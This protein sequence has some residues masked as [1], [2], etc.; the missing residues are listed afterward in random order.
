MK[1]QP[2]SHEQCREVFSE[3]ILRCQNLL[4]LHC[5]MNT[6]EIHATN[7]VIT[8]SESQ[9]RLMAAL[10]KNINCK[11][12]LINIVWHENHHQIRDNN[13]HQLVFQLRSV[14]Q[15]HNVPGKL[16]ETIPHY[17]LR[18]NTFLLEEKSGR[19]TVEDEKSPLA[20]TVPPPENM[21]LFNQRLK[22]FYR[23]VLV[24]SMLIVV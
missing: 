13:Y 3:R 1:K 11:R 5:P 4:T 20:A 9:K 7:D 12:Q 17:G 23:S 16:V 8:L 10:I 22:R 19:P 15:R 18:L 24:I 21:T 14:F 6:L 2:L